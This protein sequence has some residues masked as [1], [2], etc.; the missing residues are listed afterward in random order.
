MLIIGRSHKVWETSPPAPGVSERP[1]GIWSLA[2][3]R[4]RK[5]G[6]ILSSWRWYPHSWDNL[7]GSSGKV[8]FII[9]PRRFPFEYG[10]ILLSEW[11]VN[12]TSNPRKNWYIFNETLVRCDLEHPGTSLV[13]ACRCYLVGNVAP[14]ALGLWSFLSYHSGKKIVEVRRDKIPLI[15]L[16][17]S[18]ILF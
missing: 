18:F 1:K 15:Y 14:A 10:L 5:A 11:E 4:T 7:A 12:M 3:A 9:K 13:C 6:A 16:R 2:G 8:Y 17:A